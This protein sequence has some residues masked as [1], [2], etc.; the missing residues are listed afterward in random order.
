[1]STPETTGRSQNRR[2]PP[3]LSMIERYAVGRVSR[4]GLLLP[5]G[6]F[7][8][9]ARN[10][11]VEVRG[12]RSTFHTVIGLKQLISEQDEDPVSRV[13]NIEIDRDQGNPSVVTGLKADSYEIDDY[14]EFHGI[15]PTHHEF[16]LVNGESE[17]SAW[18]VMQSTAMAV[19]AVRQEQMRS[20]KIPNLHIN[21]P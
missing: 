2:T 19:R 21:Y 4:L 13:V 11:S 17:L 9:H 18:R 12:R 14:A 16:S 15:R 6:H 1:M 10:G 20:L 5:Q 7:S 8:A 3:K